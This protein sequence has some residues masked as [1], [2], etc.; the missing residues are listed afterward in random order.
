[1]NAIFFLLGLFLI[2]LCASALV[3]FSGFLVKKSRIS[4]K[5]SLIF[6]AM[7]FFATIVLGILRK[8]IPLEIPLFLNIVITVFLEAFLASMYFRSRALDQSG[9]TIGRHRAALIGV[10]VFALGMALIII[11]VTIETIL[12]MH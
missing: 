2:L 12:P 7:L 9:T 3:K 10:A 1:M 11:V 4:W 6:A 8:I 5:H